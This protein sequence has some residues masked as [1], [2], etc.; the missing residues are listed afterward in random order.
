VFG[1]RLMIAMGAR[2]VILTNAAGG[3]RED[4]AAGSFM[5]IDDHLNL[6]GA[7]PLCGASPEQRFVDMGQAYDRELGILAAKVATD[8]GIELAAGVYA[9]VL[10]PSYETPAEIR[11]LRA[12]GADAV[13]MSTVL[14]TI[15]ARQMGARVL[16]LSCITNAA[17]GRDGARLDHGDVQH[18]AALATERFSALVGGVLDALDAE[19]AA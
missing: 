8:A 6:T 9:G 2:V 1:V 16:G 3:I 15:A 13:G 7:N 5:R 14:E 10:G 19:D 11:M 4:L 12:L 18:A 17:A